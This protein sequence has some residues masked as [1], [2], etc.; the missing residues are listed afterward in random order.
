MRSRVTGQ[1]LGVNLFSR[2][3][4]GIEYLA[5]VAAAGHVLRARAMT[6]LATLLRRAA[7]FVQRGFP[8]RSLRPGVVNLFMTR[9][10]GVRSYVLGGVG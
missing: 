9:L 1:A 10:A 5:D 2:V 4:R 7:G 6:A 8:V 3:L